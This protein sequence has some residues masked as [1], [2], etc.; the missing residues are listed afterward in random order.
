MNVYY[1]NCKAEKDVG[2]RVYILEGVK[3]GIALLIAK[4]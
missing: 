2:G 3:T 1:A 4:R